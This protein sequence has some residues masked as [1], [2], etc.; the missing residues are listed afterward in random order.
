MIYL[1]QR[2][3]KKLVNQSNISNVATKHTTKAELKA[4]Q[5]KIVKLQI[6]DLSYFLGKIFFGDNNFQN[7]F[8]FQPTRNMLELK[9]FVIGQKSTEVYT[10]KLKSL[11]A[12]FLHGMKLS[13]YKAK[14]KFDKGYLAIEQNS[15]TTKILNAYNVYDLD[16]WPK[17]SLNSFKLKKCLP[18]ANMV[19]NTDK[20]KWVCS[21]IGIAFDGAFVEFW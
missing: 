19:K 15:Y 12:D 1:R 17:I 13:G 8:I 2:S 14:I 21:D 20:E 7:M 18:A 4:E 3:N 11:Y 5:D 6:R 16:A 9:E 10:S